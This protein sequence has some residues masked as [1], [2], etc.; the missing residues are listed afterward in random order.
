MDMRCLSN[1]ELGHFLKR[2]HRAKSPSYDLDLA[3]IFNDILTRAYD[4]VPSEAG[5][6][7]LNDPILGQDNP[8]E[9]ELVAA[10]CFGQ[11]ADRLV[12]TRVFATQGI[13]GHVYL[14]GQAYASN[15]PHNDPLFLNHIP[16]EGSFE[17]SSLICAPLHVEGETIGVIEL[18]NHRGRAGYNTTDLDLLLIFAQTISAAL[19]NAV[20]AQRSR[21]IAKRDDLTGL[22]NDRYLHHRLSQVIEEALGNHRECGL[23]FLD[24]DHFKT[25]NDA[26]G[27]LV[28]SR[29]LREVGQTLRQVLP[30][31]AIAARYG[32]DE[33]VIVV[34]GAGRQEVYWIA[35]TVR[36]NLE[37]AVFLE[38]ADPND[39]LNYPALEIR[40]IIT[41]SLGIATLRSDVLPTVH[42]D[43]IDPVAAKNELIRQA[44]ASMYQAKDTGRNLTVCAWNEDEASGSFQ[45]PS[46]VPEEPSV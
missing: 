25:I 34:P 30:G 23:I 7:F 21:E 33:F 9:H 8:A 5:S 37:T 31:Q 45:Q 28:G 15:D 18:I 14:T 32:G 27:H 20:E 42:S 19:T 46:H 26:Y 16:S 3:H 6:I 35:E 4:F 12:G 2:E 41:C 10:I 40:R 24:L 1:P 22:F 11:M 44:D 29:V 38:H 43:T 17:I 39:P 36:K 13:V